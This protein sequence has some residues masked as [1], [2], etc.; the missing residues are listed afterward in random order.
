ILYNNFS[1]DVETSEPS[2]AEK[3]VT[4][5]FRYAAL[6]AKEPEAKIQIP[7]RSVKR[8][9]IADTFHEPRGE[10]RLHQGQDIFAPRG[11]PVYSA[12]D[13]YVWRIR[14]NRLGGNTVW[15]LGA[16]GRVYY[17]A[18]LD[19]YAPELKVGD[20]VTTDTILGFVG[21]TGNAKGT[22]PHLHFGVYTMGGAIN[23]LPLFE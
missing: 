18:H 12:T 5:P 7:I 15:V 16:G 6:L 8:R 3:T 10:D 4:A 2:T 11:T 20:E 23:P 9:Q 1:P 13:G 17:Y 14:E 21:N 22:P 19:R